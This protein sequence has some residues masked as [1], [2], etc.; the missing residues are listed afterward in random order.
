M[1]QNEIQFLYDYDK[2]ADLKLLEVIAMITK[3]QYME[4]PWFKLWRNTWNYCAH[5]FFQ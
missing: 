5:S 2:W 4:R 3:D 1:T